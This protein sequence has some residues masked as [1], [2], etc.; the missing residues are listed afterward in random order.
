MR[1]DVP[2]NSDGYLQAFFGKAPTRGKSPAAV[3]TRIAHGESTRA[4]RAI[5]D[6][7][8]KLKRDTT[9][10]DVQRVLADADFAQR[11]LIKARTAHATAREAALAEAEDLRRRMASKLRPA[12]SVGAMADAEL[13]GYLRT[14]KPEDRSRIL[15][16]AKSAGDLDTLRAFAGAAPYLSGLGAEAH[17]SLLDAYLSVVAT[18]EREE[19]DAVEEGLR[20][21]DHAM[22]E[23]EAHANHYIDFNAA[24]RLIATKVEEAA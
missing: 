14:L 23:L 7:H 20:K 16:E 5:Y 21:A 9:K 11:E 12:D 18:E 15:A 19:L 1:A 22:S 10:S 3:H 4:W 24:A 17:A 2:P 8:L 13:R 6:R